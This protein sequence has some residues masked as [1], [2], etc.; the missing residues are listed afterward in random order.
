M[1]HSEVGCARRVVLPSTRSEVT[2]LVHE[3]GLVHVA[4]ALADVSLHVTQ[5]S[6]RVLDSLARSWMDLD[7]NEPEPEADPAALRWGG[8]AV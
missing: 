1:T 4:A 2:V 6:V 8:R 3:G 5:G 7:M